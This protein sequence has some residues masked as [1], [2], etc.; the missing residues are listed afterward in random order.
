[1]DEV[2]SCFIYNSS[3]VK[4]SSLVSFGS[5]M[6]F[7]PS[8]RKLNEGFGGYGRKKMDLIVVGNFLLNLLTELLFLNNI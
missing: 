6:F 8:F 1:M 3:I 4:K 5:Q 2:G 7:R